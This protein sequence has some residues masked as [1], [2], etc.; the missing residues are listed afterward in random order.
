MSR[1]PAVAVL[2]LALLVGACADPPPA[3]RPSPGA[4]ASAEPLSAELLPPERGRFGLRL[5]REPHV[6]L[7]EVVPD[8]GMGLVHPGSAEVERTRPAGTSS[9]P[10]RRTQLRK[11]RDWYR[12]ESP[13]PLNQPAPESLKS[14]GML[15]LVASE[16]PLDLS[17]VDEAGEIR[18]SIAD[19]AARNPYGAMEQLVDLILPRRDDVSWAFDVWMAEPPA[20]GD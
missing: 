1:L 12:P 4:E 19:D 3:D 5:N 15:F 13:G 6:A 8:R 17:A 14:Q 18:R 11:H 20:A 10:I 2:P 9:V 7:F 16:R